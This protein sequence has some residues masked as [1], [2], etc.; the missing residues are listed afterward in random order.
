M[1]VEPSSDRRRLSLAGKAAAL[2]VAL[3]VLQIAILAR[4]LNPAAAQ[5]RDGEARR[6]AVQ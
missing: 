5:A 2:V 1:A 4:G 3:G 6:S